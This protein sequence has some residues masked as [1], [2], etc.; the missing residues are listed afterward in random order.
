MAVAIVPLTMV[1]VSSD[2]ADRSDIDP[3]TGSTTPAESPRDDPSQVTGSGLRAVADATVEA[4]NPN[5]SDGGSTTLRSAV[6]PEIRSYV[7]FDVGVSGTVPRAVVT[8]HALADSNAG[9][10]IYL[11]KGAWLEQDVTFATAPRLVRV[12]DSSGPVRS[13]DQVQLDVTPAMDGRGSY[14]FAIVTSGSRPITLLSRESEHPPT[15]A[16]GT[17]TWCRGVVIERGDSIQRAIDRFGEGATFCIRAGLHR[18]TRRLTP[19]D[20]Q[21][22]IGEDGAILNGSKRLTSFRREGGYWV[23]DNQTQELGGGN[24]EC[25]PS[26]YTGCRLPERVFLDGKSLWQV[27]SLDALSGG[28]FYFDHDTDKIYLSANPKGHAIETTV[29]TALFE[30]WAARD[31]VVRNLI[32]EKFGTLAQGSTL[33]G[34]S[35]TGWTIVGNEVRNNSGVGICGGANALVWANDVHDQGQMGMCGQ[36]AGGTYVNNTIS[37]NNVDGFFVYWEAGGS[38]FV[39]TTGL[40]VL[41][42][43]IHD[44]RGTALW[45]DGDNYRTRYLNNRVQDNQGLGILH[46]ISYDATIKYNFITKN[47]SLTQA[48]LDGAGIMVASSSNVTVS[49]NTVIDNADGIVFKQHSTES[50]NRGPFVVRDALVKENVILICEGESGGLETVGDGAIFTGRNNLFDHNTYLLDPHRTEFWRWM[51]DF[52]TRDGW[53]GLGQDRN[54]TFEA[55]TC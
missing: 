9:F 29:V 20:H 18:I 10:E 45:T 39:A 28:E 49:R 22:F 47:G 54:S 13:G 2:A 24:G 52:W 46:E 4:A 6:W 44:N 26:S 51:G 32:I 5:Q 21:R 37:H 8:L 53:V 17:G 41:G 30:D 42:N 16:V 31:V 35:A 23:A 14:T 11:A 25:Q 27:T 36:H 1:L 38:K 3:P 55:A 33:G 15:L 48:E 34:Q 43:F 19:R 7:R 40:T 50:G 12:L